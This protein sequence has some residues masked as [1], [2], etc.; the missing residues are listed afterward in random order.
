[1]SL[2]DDIQ[3]RLEQWALAA[4]QE[5]QEVLDDAVLCGSDQPG[6]RALL[7]EHTEI[8]KEIFGGDE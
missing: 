3:T 2:S 4:A 7:A 1:V 6:I 5:L 8:N